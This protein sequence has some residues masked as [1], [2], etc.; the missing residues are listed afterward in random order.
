MVLNIV[1]SKILIQNQAAL[2]RISKIA[3]FQNF[4]FRKESPFLRHET[5]SND[6]ISK[7]LSKEGFRV[8]K[9]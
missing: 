3:I 6:R 8:P 2:L 1:F 5:R 4:V 9:F 7:N